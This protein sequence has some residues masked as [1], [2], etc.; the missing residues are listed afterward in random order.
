[1][2][3]SQGQKPNT[4]P[5]ILTF[6]SEFECGNLE[7]AFLHETKLPKLEVYSLF[8]QQDTNSDLPSNWFF[9]TAS[10]FEPTT[11]YKFIIQVF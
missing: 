4:H 5:K 3:L 10:N 7:F 6:K 8:P 11:T 9:F 2:F 1:M